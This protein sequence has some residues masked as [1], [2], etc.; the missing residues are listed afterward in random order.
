MI[1][2]LIYSIISA[3]HAL[4]VVCFILKVYPYAGIKKGRYS[5]ERRAVLKKQI[6]GAQSQNSLGIPVQHSSSAFTDTSQV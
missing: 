3:V 1:F 2:N 6:V 5:Y 4:A